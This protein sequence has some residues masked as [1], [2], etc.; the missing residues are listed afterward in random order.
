MFSVP[1]KFPIFHSQR[2]YN[3]L[4]C[5]YS[6]LWVTKYNA[7]PINFII[8]SANQHYKRTVMWLIDL[9]CLLCYISSLAVGDFVA[10]RIGS[11]GRTGTGE[12]W[13]IFYAKVRF[14]KIE[15]SNLDLLT[16]MDQHGQYISQ[17][18]SWVEQLNK[19]LPYYSNNLF[20]LQAA[21]VLQLLTLTQ[22]QK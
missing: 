14:P 19:N 15:K 9:L 6:T 3:A 4:Y 17:N 12:Q 18:N 22:H 10:V 5:M 20:L 21:M 8:Q 7:K 16:S 11:A 1:S 2:K 13:S